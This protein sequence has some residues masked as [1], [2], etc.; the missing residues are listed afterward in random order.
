MTKNMLHGVMCLCL[1]VLLNACGGSTPEVIRIPVTKTV[2]EKIQTPH[3]LLRDCPEPNLDTLDTNG[4]LERALGEAI[5]ALDVCTED[6]RKIR[7]WQEAEA[8]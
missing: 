7:S 2:V 3:E 4:D 6:K 1:M 5:V 8:Q